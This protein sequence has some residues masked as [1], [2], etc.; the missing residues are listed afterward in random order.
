M[1]NISQ[2]LNSIVRAAVWRAV[3]LMPPAVIWGIVG[4]AFVWAL[5]AGGRH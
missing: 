4:A 3:W 1:P 5:I 2:L